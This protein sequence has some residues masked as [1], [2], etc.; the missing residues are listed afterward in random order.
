MWQ[1]KCIHLFHKHRAHSVPKQG[2]HFCADLI[3]RILLGR[4]LLWCIGRS[5][6]RPRAQAIDVRTALQHA[7]AAAAAAAAARLQLRLWLRL[8]LRLRLAR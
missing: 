4:Q 1:T 5:K 7:A 6:S 3:S 2:T 8:W